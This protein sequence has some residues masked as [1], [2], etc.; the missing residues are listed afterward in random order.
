MVGGRGERFNVVFGKMAGVG[1][2]VESV[3][4]VLFG[5][6]EGGEGFTWFC[7]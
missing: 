1:H 4:L 6:G 5:G 7:W 2:L 3:F